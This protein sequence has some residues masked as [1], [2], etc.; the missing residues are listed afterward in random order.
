MPE[1]EHYL[2]TAPSYL[3]T[4]LA[5]FRH[6]SAYQLLT[7]DLVCSAFLPEGQQA[8][9]CKRLLLIS[10]SFDLYVLG[11]KHDEVQELLV[12]SGATM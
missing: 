6:H 7:M 11:W 9:S 2:E 8:A 12:N 1:E 5:N 10:I 3:S 4:F